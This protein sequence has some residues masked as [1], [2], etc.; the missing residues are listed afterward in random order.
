M[1]YHNNCSTVQ[2]S[3]TRR[4]K[5]GIDS[6]T[7]RLLSTYAKLLFDAH[8]IVNGIQNGV[9]PLDVIL[10]PKDRLG[11][12][13]IECGARSNWRLLPRDNGQA[14]LQLRPRLSEK[15]GR[16]LPGERARGYDEPLHRVGRRNLDRK[17]VRARD[18]A[19]VD[20]HRREA[21]RGVEPADW[22]TRWAGDERIGV[23]VRTRC[24]RV[25]H[26]A[27]AERPV[28]VRRM[29]RGQVQI[30]MRAFVIAH[31]SVRE[32]LGNR[33]DEETR[34]AGL[35]GLFGRLWVVC[36]STYGRWG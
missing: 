19:H 29:D 14:A 22:A 34:C 26:L 31:G 23:R 9:L 5:S 36:C 11:R 13:C 16:L 35:E 28:D 27:R 32:A 24:G 33:V 2:C 30:W 4:D 20:V 21:D 12:T 7:L 25:V 17:H 18:V 15:L 10:K 6:K 8:H 3:Y 1:N